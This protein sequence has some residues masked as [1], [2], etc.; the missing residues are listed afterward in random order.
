MQRIHLAT[1]AS[2]LLLVLTACGTTAE[3]TTALAVEP[4]EQP[5]TVLLPDL[6]ADHL[7]T[8]P[9]ASNV[10][11]VPVTPGLVVVPSGIR[12]EN[13]TVR[14]EMY[15]GLAVR[16]L[17]DAPYG[18]LLGGGN[19]AA[20]KSRTD[21]VRASQA[22]VVVD[23]T[24]ISNPRFN[25]D[26]GG[27]W[28]NPEGQAWAIFQEVTVRVIERW[29]DGLGLSDK[30]SFFAVGGSVEV[31]LSDEQARAIELEKGGKYIF[32]TAPDFDLTVG[33]RVVLFLA[34]DGLGWEGGLAPGLVVVGAGQGKFDFVGDSLA[35]ATRPEWEV[36]TSDIRAE[37]AR[38]LGKN[39]PV[40]QST[41]PPADTNVYRP[42]P[43]DAT[44]DLTD[45]PDHTHG[46][47]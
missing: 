21:L 38:D 31:E 26:D 42:G 4:L 20:F 1:L 13:G 27:F 6:V 2:A 34:L 8:L 16:S 33:D 46:E 47:P 9:A 40:L 18:P 22:V 10:A 43:G 23:I 5:D 19:V 7:V 15:D 14:S 28:V 17:S 25:S 3:P 11:T 36:S 32:S 30:F 37:I 35:P 41:S 45:T 44:E 29:G 24:A 39:P 12:N